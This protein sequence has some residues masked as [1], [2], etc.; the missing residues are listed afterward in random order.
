MSE[1]FRVLLADDHPLVVRAL[2]ALLEREHDFEVVGEVDDF[3]SLATALEKNRP[4]VLVVDVGMPGGDAVEMVRRARRDDKDLRVLVLSGFPE[5]DFIVRM[6][7]A[8]A[9]GYARKDADPAE[10]LAAI[11]KVANGHMSISEAGAL[12]LA[13]SAAGRGSEHEK[14]SDRELQVLRL[15]GRG[16]SV[17]DI[18]V[19]LHLSPKTISTYRVRM[20]E[21]M[22]F[23]TTA[24]II[25]YAVRRGL[26]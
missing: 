16:S 25:R 2:R 13:A 24:D 10:L 8:G 14:L 17:G 15:L 3:R 22:G 4:D 6:I 26:V 5:E 11:R 18:A 21:K 1:V 23:T 9:A 7:D 12:A 20:M 19:E